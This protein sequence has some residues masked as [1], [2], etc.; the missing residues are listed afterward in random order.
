MYYGPEIMIAA[1]IKIGNY[2]D[3]ISGLILNI[4]LS[5]TNAVGTTISIF[6]IDR[7][8]RRYMMLRSLPV[9]VIT[10]LIVAGGMFALPPSGTDQSSIGGDLAFTGTL[11]FLLA[12][13]IG[14][15]ST[16]WAVCA[17]IFP[18]HV[19]GT[20]NSLTTTTNWVSNFVVAWFF[21]LMLSNDSL[22]GWAFVLLAIFSAL[23]WLFIFLMLPE[24]ANKTQQE[25]L[26]AILGDRYETRQSETLKKELELDHELRN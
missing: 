7:L 6:F 17:E 16:P 18:L 5:L 14:M 11:L 19:V 8:G 23:A 15:S 25:N 4:P 22:K 9:I 24:T 21:P 26:K 3:K 1:N 20:A 10:L 2:S 13:G 12:F